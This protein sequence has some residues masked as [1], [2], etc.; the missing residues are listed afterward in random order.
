MNVF[1]VRLFF[2]IY[3]ILFIFGSGNVRLKDMCYFN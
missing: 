2:Y 1:V 3:D